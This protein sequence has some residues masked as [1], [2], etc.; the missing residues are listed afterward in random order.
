MWINVGIEREGKY[1]KD[2]INS[3]KHWSEYIISSDF[4]F[5]IDTEVKKMYTVSL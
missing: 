5:S 2:T 3:I 1:L 4:S